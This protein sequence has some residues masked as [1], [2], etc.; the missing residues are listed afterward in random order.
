MEVLLIGGPVELF[1]PLETLE[2][3]PGFLDEGHCQ[4]EGKRGDIGEEEAHFEGRDQLGE[5]DQQE[6]HVEEELKLVVQYYRDESQDV[7]LSVIDLVIHVSLRHIPSP[8]DVNR[9]FL[10]IIT[11]PLL[12]STEGT[13]LKHLRIA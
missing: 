8:I 11:N 13:R 1:V 12:T 4:H 6:E 10:K 5:A 3:I 7:V 9:S 2:V